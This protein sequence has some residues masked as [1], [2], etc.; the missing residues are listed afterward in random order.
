MGS[1]LIYF[2]HAAAMGMARA[3][4]LT[5]A[6]TITLAA[7]LFV[8]GA[9]GM[10]LHGA[11]NL[12]HAW[13]QGGHISCAIAL[14]VPQA[15]WA[16]LKDQVAAL[17]GVAHAELITP[18]QALQAFAARGPE[19][20]ALV[21]GVAATALPASLRVQPQGSMMAQEAMAQLA[22]QLRGMRGIED[23]AYGELKLERVRAA[24]RALAMLALALG[25]L[26][27]VAMVFMVANTIRLMIYARQEEVRILRLVGAT[28]WFVR[29]PF[30]LEG[31]TWGVMAGF[32]GGGALWGLDYAFAEHLHHAQQTLGQNAALHV[33]S[34]SMLMAQ[35][36]TGA[37]LGLLGSFMALHRFLDE[38][39]G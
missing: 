13:G 15:R 7:A 8:M 28:A 2:V 34:G 1:R 35:V 14:D 26:F 16:A 29:A 23:V 20:A 12:A 17:P 33:F 4:S 11:R 19:A 3:R 30:L 21:E 39:V 27:F 10:A 31:L 37:V 18:E 32:L 5:A 24:I 6:S 25:A 9:F 22:S 38:D 36:A